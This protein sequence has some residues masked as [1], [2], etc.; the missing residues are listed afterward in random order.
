MA[1]VYLDTSFFIGY[2][3]N[4]SDRREEAERILAYEKAEQSHLLTSVLTINE[5]LCRTYD[6]HKHADDCS[7]Q[8]RQTERR[9]RAIAAPYALHPDILRDAA[10]LLSVWGERNRHSPGTPPRDKKFRWDALHLATANHLKCARV[11]AWDVQV[12]YLPDTRPSGATVT[13]RSSARPPEALREGVGDPRPG[14]RERRRARQR[15]SCP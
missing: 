7:E 6:E 13:R 14:G 3:E 2:L 10:R 4:Q 12:S 1:N 15:A 5:F 9:L 8:V 11:Y